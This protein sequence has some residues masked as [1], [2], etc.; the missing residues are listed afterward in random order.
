M[1]HAEQVPQHFGL[2]ARQANQHRAIADVVV[3]YVVHIGIGGKQFGAVIEI[4]A[5]DQRS[6][7]GRAI[8]G[9]ASQEFSMDLEG[10]RTVR[11]ALLY[12]GQR[13]SD[14]PHSVEVDGGSGQRSVRFLPILQGCEAFACAIFSSNST[15]RAAE[16]SLKISR[17]TKSLGSVFN[18]ATRSVMVPE[19]WFRVPPQAYDPNSK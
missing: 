13:K 3:R 9:D 8:R 16:N 15:S 19:G 6:R 12:A 10:G 4:H 1:G 2:D 11:G 14:I 17:F 18:F 5:D 7:F